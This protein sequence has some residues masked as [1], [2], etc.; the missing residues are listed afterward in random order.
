MD[1]IIGTGKASLSKRQYHIKVERDVFVPV[2]AGH[3]ICVDV[4]RPDGDGKF[5]AL[6]SMS[7]YSKEAQSE[8]HW[9][10]GIGSK[11]IRGAIDGAVE[12]GPTD[13]FVRR[14]YA[15]IIGSVRGVGKSG[16]TY[17][18]MDKGEHRD[19]HDVVEWA[20]Q[21]PWC[22][23]NVGMMGLS[24]FGWNQVSTA[25]TK[26]PHLKAIAPFFAATDQYRDA[27]YHGGILSAQFHSAG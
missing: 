20:A 6:V 25:A 10:G 7:P 17:R 19:L 15:H 14:G 16:G 21:Q 13:F 26:P 27:W 3:K 22:N 4:F 23:G 1:A 8:R 12:A 18:F 11:F 9:P 24:Y 2:S 5:P